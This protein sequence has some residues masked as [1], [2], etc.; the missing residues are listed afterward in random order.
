MCLNHV[1][2][3][4]APTDNLDRPLDSMWFLGNNNNSA[5]NYICFVIAYCDGIHQRSF[6][7]KFILKTT[8]RYMEVL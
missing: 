5:V 4:H 3:V 7:K 2:Y 1:N 8:F 6:E